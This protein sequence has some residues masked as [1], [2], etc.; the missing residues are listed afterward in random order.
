[1]IR[2]ALPNLDLR[3]FSIRNPQS[4]IRNRE[5]VFSDIDLKIRL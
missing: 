5:L 1:M 3:F 2:S 4:A